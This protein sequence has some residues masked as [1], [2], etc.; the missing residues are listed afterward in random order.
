[1]TSKQTPH[2]NEKGV[3]SETTETT[4][5]TETE[6]VNEGAPGQGGYEKLK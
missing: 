1:M 6:K 3:H 4:E 2:A 5:T